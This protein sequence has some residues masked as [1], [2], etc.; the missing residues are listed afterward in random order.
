MRKAGF[1]PLEEVM[2]KHLTSEHR[3]V[4]EELTGEG[5]CKDPRS[6]KGD[7]YYA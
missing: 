6:E 3:G 2:L 5:R 1:I 4:A 7:V